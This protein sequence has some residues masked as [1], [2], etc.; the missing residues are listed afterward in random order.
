MIAQITNLFIIIGL[1][2][3]TIPEISHLLLATSFN[4]QGKSFL[5]LFGAFIIAL[6]ISLKSIISL[7][8]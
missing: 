5:K 7:V 6:A 3:H 1:F 4:T 8:S 2:I